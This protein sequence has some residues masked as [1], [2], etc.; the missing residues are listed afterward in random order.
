VI[1]SAPAPA[2]LHVPVV[3]LA[4]APDVKDPNASKTIPFRNFFDSLTRLEDLHHEGGAQQEGAAVKNSSTK[5]ER[6]ELADPGTEELVVP[7]TP[8]PS[9]PKPSLAL[10]QSVLG[11]MPGSN[12]PAEETTLLPST[13]SPEESDVKAAVTVTSLPTAPAASL[14]YAPQTS[15][16]ARMTVTALTAEK[17]QVTARLS[18]TQSA[19][20][21]QP[22]AKPLAAGSVSM[23]P[24]KEEAAGLAI[25]MTA[26]AVSPATSLAAEKPVTASLP[27]TQSTTVETAAPVSVKAPVASSA[28]TAEKLPVSN[29]AEAVAPAAPSKPAERLSPANAQAASPEQAPVP[30]E[31]TAP[32]PQPEDPSVRVAKIAPNDP[33]VPSSPVLFLER[34]SLAPLPADT[35]VIDRAAQPEAR[36][37]TPAPNTPLLPQAENLAFA[38]RIEP[39][40]PPN[41]SSATQTAPFSTNETPLTQSKTPVTPPQSSNSQQ[42]PASGNQTSS[43]PGR[44]TQPAAPETERSDAGAKNLSYSLGTQPAP[45]VTQHWSDAA[46]WQAPDL[47][48]LPGTPEP[49]EAAH[50][51]LPLAAQEAHLL[52]P[53]L[54]K[55]SASSEILLHL[56]GNDQSAAA[57]R[58]T[59]RAGSVNVSVHASDPVLRESLR[60]NLG[61][62]STQLN[63]QGWKADVMKSAVAAMQSSGP[64]DSHEDG[65]RGSQ[66]Q[67]S[68]GGDRPPQRDRRANGGQWQQELDQQISGGEAHSGGNG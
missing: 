34:E 4:P 44:E 7:Q 67:Q 57:I 37:V 11:V 36:A 55:T 62:L 8:S 61:E 30:V 49:A 51:S 33:S 38:M 59:D 28:P 66:P 60:S 65:Q 29:S 40:S 46:A 12:A 2:A 56:T 1:V 39:V 5:K 47:S 23:P 43:N 27:A 52:A 18:A 22:T 24:D 54:P 45:G 19:V 20:E 58:V 42:P 3:S 26:Q 21:P 64:R 9:L 10:L 68:F 16:T 48:P 13:S 35:E 50:A 63:G 15:N 53:D 41:N 17:E 6:P 14:P 32:A 31:I 25:R